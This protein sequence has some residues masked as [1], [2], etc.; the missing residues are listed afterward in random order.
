MS[1]A[2]GRRTDRTDDDGIQVRAADRRYARQTPRMFSVPP[3]SGTASTDRRGHPLEERTLCQ[4]GGTYPM[5]SSTF[6]YRRA[7]PEAMQTARS[8]CLHVS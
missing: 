6:E 5:V 1:T 2:C 7:S 4:P 8:G 3:L